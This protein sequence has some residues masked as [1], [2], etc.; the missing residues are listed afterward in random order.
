MKRI[1]VKLS[2]PVVAPLLDVVKELA[3]HLK[4]RLAAPQL[5]PE[6]EEEFL[7]AWTS[8]LLESQAA[9]VAVL[10][11]LFDEEFFADGVIALDESNAEPVV[12]ACAAVRLRLREKFLKDVG[13]E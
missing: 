8:D 6:A 4:E 1:E 7:E 3:D 5:M 2:L 12:R 9:D 13:D 11:A 10:L